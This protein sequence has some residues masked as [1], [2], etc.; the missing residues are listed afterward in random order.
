[1]VDLR[2][3]PHNLQSH[4]PQMT[5]KIESLTN[6]LIAN[7]YTNPHSLNFQRAFQRVEEKQETSSNNELQ[8]HSNYLGIKTMT[9][10]QNPSKMRFQL[11]EQEIRVPVVAVRSG[12][13]PGVITKCPHSSLK[14]FAKGMCNHCYHRYGRKSMVTN[15]EHK[16]RRNYAKGK[17]QN[18][19]INDYNRSK[20]ESLSTKQAKEA[21]AEI[22]PEL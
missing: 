10:V 3:Q 12:R 1:M 18:C 13:K 15:C 9:E 20:R 19:Y 21:I 4:D 11:N 5:S 7:Y 14:H 6:Q 17:C 2:A 22:D 8:N 16:D